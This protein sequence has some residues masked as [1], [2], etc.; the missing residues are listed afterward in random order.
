MKA[1]RKATRKKYETSRGDSVIFPCTVAR[2]GSIVA[3][4]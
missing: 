3:H 4:A 2:N 1:L